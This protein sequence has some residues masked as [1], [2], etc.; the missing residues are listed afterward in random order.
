MLSTGLLVALFGFFQA[1]TSTDA[2]EILTQL[3][4][5]RLDKS[6]MYSVRDLTI[7][8]DVLSI[9]LNRG[10]LAFLE[11]VNGKITGAVFVGNGEIVA[12][13]PDPIEKQQIYKFTGTPILNEPFQT[14]IFRFTDNTYDEVRKDIAEH[15]QDEISRDEAAPL[16]SLDIFSAT[17]A[18][19]LNVRLLSDFLETPARPLFLGALK[20]DRTGWFNVVFDLRAAEEVSV[21]QVRQIGNSAVADIWASFHQRSEARNPEAVA[22][23]DKSPVEILSYDF[24]GSVAP[25]DNLDIKL[26]IVA[27][28]RT[29]SAR[30][31]RFDLSPAFHIGSVLADNEPAACFQYPD[32]KEAVVVLP[33][34]LK[35]DQQL[36]LQFAYS[37]KSA[38]DESWYPFQPQD[39][40]P[41][42]KSALALPED[43]STPAL[44]YSGR[45]VVAATYHDE[46]LMQGLAR[47][48]AALSAEATNPPDRALRKL[49]DD[50]REDLK[51]LDAAGPIWLGRRLISTV[52]PEGG[53]AVVA[54][55]LWVIHMLRMMLRI[56]GTNPDARFFAMV[57][58]F[59][60]TYSGRSAS[61]WDFKH[62]AEKYAGRKLDWFFDQWVFATGIPKYSVDYRIEAAGGEF[63]IEGRITQDGVPD[64]FSMPVPLYADADY[65]GTVDVGDSEGQFRF[66]LA[67]QPER[68][69]IDPEMTVLTSALP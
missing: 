9:S 27:K 4:R 25:D 61:T 5:I 1:S 62:L 59:A 10:V 8:R 56:A 50:A 21:F 2:D 41:S 55:S 24:E 18:N 45:K 65:L 48:V 57:E 36:M 11:P 20:G 32:S 23:E 17:R 15:A 42:F 26:S 49:L 12:I 13:P 52:T 35:R 67:R 30:V 58:D 53:R 34:P 60:Q 38:G 43:R 14:A 28:A 68:I 66:R 7:R 29:E 64:G 3:S 47:Y 51:L 69:L 54:K 40:I 16:D 39:K 22:H 44:Q 6:Q 37:G 19:A 31:L 33:H 63:M 46:W